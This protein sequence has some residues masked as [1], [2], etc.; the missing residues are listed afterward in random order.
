MADEDN[1]ILVTMGK[2]QFVAL[3]KIIIEYRNGKRAMYDSKVTR[4]L[5]LNENEIL[6]IEEVTRELRDK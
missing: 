6:S 2:T 4:K 1:K 3:Q 5:Y